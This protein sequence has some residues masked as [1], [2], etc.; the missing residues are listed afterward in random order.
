MDF[1][2]TNRA[3]ILNKRFWMFEDKTELLILIQIV[4]KQNKKSQH[5][6][7]NRRSDDHVE[8]LTRVGCILSRRKWTNPRSTKE[9]TYKHSH[10]LILIFIH[11]VKCP[12]NI[13]FCLSLWTLSTKWVVLKERRWSCRKIN[14]SGVHIVSQKTDDNVIQLH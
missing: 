12:F 5:V 9:T 4:N 3:S 10:N 13:L 14:K 11:C 2:F 7:L 6:R 8:K 1:S